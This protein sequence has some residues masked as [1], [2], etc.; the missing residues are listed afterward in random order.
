MDINNNKANNI[1]TLDGKNFKI[2]P[3]YFYSQI[4]Q[5][6]NKKVCKKLYFHKSIV[7]NSFYV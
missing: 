3:L 2:N 5:A 7:Q 6:T 4:V 1:K